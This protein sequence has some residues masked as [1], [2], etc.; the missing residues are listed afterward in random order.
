[1][2]ITFHPRAS[3]VGAESRKRWKLIELI[4]G[5]GDRGIGLKS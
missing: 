1:V 4:T 2:E 5:L 3:R